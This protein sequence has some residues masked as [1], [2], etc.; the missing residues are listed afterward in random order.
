ML[1]LSIFCSSQ[2]ISVALY[3]HG[4]LTKFYEKEIVDGR[5]EGIFTLM[6]S[7]KEGNSF[8]NL[9]KFFLLMDQEVLQR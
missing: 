1:A 9:E 4:V 2:T 8:N 7:A 3:S 5:I 6:K